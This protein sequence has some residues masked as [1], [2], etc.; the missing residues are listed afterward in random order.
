MQGTSVG[1]LLSNAAAGAMII[2][3]ACTGATGDGPFYQGKR[4]TV[5]INYPAGGP[6][7]SEARVIAR[8]LE[9]HIPGQPAI[10]ARNMPG[11][12]G[13]AA[14]NYMGDI[15]APDGLTV[16]MFSPPVIHQLLR[17][18][19]LRV[20]LAEFVWLAGVVQPQVCFIRKDAGGGIERV[21]DLRR[22]REFSTAGLAP[23]AATDIKFRLALELLGA[24]Y[25]YVT[26]YR[27]LAA[28][29]IAVMQNE[30]QFSCGS[31]TFLRRNIGPNLIEPGLAIPLWYYSVADGDGNEVRDEQLG[32][33]PT[34]LDVH[35]RMMG[36]EPSGLRYE[37][38]QLVNDLSVG[39]L[40]G[41]FVPRGTPEE[42]VEALRL[43]WERLGTDDEFIAEYTRVA[44]V[45]PTLLMA[46]E[47][48]ELVGSLSD[49]DPE[50]VDFIKAFI[51]R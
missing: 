17:E 20:D 18:P 33:I 39:L 10:I 12:G 24:P 42:A 21:E 5:L 1:R 47:A 48:Q 37:A 27:G 31:V 49:A 2:L 19:G 44:S 41:S 6:T 14:T 3:M 22:I 50:I 23:T 38:L 9:K 46:A 7:D 8:H 29:A 25:R 43:G 36:D 51:D 15:A 26:G 30:V 4:I 11:G 32:E 13:V 16:A 34:F 45:P 40:R 35:R 28:A